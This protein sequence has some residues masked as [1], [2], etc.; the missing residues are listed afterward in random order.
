MQSRRDDPSCRIDISGAA[1]RDAGDWK[2]IS[3]R[4]LLYVQ[5]EM[6][7]VKAGDRIRIVG[8]LSLPPAAHNPGEFDRAVYM[9]AHR[10]RALI[11]S[12]SE[13]ISIV[14]PGGWNLTGWLDGLRKNAAALFEQQLDAR[15]AE[16]ASAV[17][18]GERELIDSERNEA[19]MA[20]GTIHILSISGLHVGILAGAYALY[21][22][23]DSRF[24]ELLG[25]RSWLRSPASTL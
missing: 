13:C 11:Q 8:D 2:P 12:Q 7:P 5:G 15:Q 10:I 6:P 4:A 3:G 19:F 1:I 14:Q 9:R 20:T 25:W 23:L 24:R 17:F 16:L 22:A 21:C 18:L